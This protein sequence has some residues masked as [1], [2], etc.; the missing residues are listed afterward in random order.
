MWEQLDQRGGIQATD[1]PPMTKFTIECY[2]CYS[3]M[4]SLLWTSCPGSSVAERFTAAL[5]VMR[6]VIH[7]GDA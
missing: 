6:Q 5:P 4:H 7:L 2:Q 1:S 3:S